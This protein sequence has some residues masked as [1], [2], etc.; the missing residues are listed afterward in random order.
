MNIE[1]LKNNVR[2]RFDVQVATP[3]SLSTEY[4]NLEI[5]KPEHPTELWARASVL[6]GESKQVQLGNAKT[7]RHRGVLMVALFQELGRG[8]K[9]TNAMVDIITAAFRAL[10][11]DSV[12]YMT[13]SSPTAG[14]VGEWWQTNL[15]CPF[16]VDDVS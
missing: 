13:P 6:M 12:V 10:T 5:P 3:Q 4:D 14:R 16:Y 9:V 2:T 8:D 15:S 1:T 7:F 11:A